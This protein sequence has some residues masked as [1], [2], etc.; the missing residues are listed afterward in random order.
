MT[1]RAPIALLLAALLLAGCGQKDTP[2]PAPAPT[3]APT[4]APS[5][6]ATPVAAADN[7]LGRST[8][9]KVCGLCHAAGIGG[10]PKPGDKADWA[11]RLAQGKDTLYR[12]ALEGFTG[13][14]GQMPARGGNAQLPDG[15]VKAAVDYMLSR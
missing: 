3:P 8:F 5:A 10:A 2:A 6:P 9:N 7:E 15:D 13:K 4:A 14:K 12:H 11:E 1:T